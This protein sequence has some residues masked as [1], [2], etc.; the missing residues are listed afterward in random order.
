VLIEVGDDVY[1]LL[2]YSGSFQDFDHRFLT[3]FLSNLRSSFHFS[4]SLCYH[5][6]GSLELP[7]FLVC[8][9]IFLTAV[10]IDV[11]NVSMS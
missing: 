3:D 5:L 2:V 4:N 1:F 6:H 8:D 10:F 11:I 9:L 7:G